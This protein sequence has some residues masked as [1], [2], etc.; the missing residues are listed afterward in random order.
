MKLHRF[1]KFTSVSCFLSP[2]HLICL[3]STGAF[4]AATFLTMPSQNVCHILNRPKDL[5][6]WKRMGTLK[7]LQSEHGEPQAKISAPDQEATEPAPPDPLYP[8]WNI[9][10]LI[11]DKGCL[12]SLTD[13]DICLLKAPH[14]TYLVIMFLPPN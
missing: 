9:T 13:S 6:Y 1:P 4:Y 5:C 14:Q 2:M 7:C 3:H 12:I 8:S 11:D 10:I